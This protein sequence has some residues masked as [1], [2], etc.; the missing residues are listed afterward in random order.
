MAKTID[1]LQ[2]E[3]EKKK[4]R[5]SQ[6]RHKEQRFKN[7]LKY[8]EKG[9][10]GKRTH[11][12]WNLGGTSPVA[13]TAFLNR[14]PEIRRVNLY[15]D[16]DFAGLKNARAIQTAIRRDPRY[17][18]LRIGI[19]PPRKGKDYNDKLQIKLMKANMRQ[20]ISRVGRYIDNRPMEGYWKLHFL[21]KFHYAAVT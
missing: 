11:R 3:I 20:S 7:R 6:E 9:E 10:R 17:K 1:Q 12:L 8:Y 2:A 14:H 16:N 21:L 18:H 4:A 19:H 13:L 15:M 5:L